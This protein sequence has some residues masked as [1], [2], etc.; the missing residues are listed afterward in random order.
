MDRTGHSSFGES[1]RGDTLLARDGSG[2]KHVQSQTEAD[3]EI[4][5]GLFSDAEVR[6]LLDDWLVPALVDSLIGDILNSHSRSEFPPQKE[7][8]TK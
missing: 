3:L 5:E 4:D 7:K 2:E 8:Q 1:P 6:G